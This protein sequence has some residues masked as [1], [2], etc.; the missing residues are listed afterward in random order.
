L[1][2]KHYS[3]RTEQAYLG[4]IRRFTRSNGRRHPREM[5]GA[6]VEAF[7][8]ALAIKGNVAAG[9][10]NRLAPTVPPRDEADR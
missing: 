4:W 6:E 5:S 10:Q 8:S 1:R 7:F 2:L 9:T 3:L